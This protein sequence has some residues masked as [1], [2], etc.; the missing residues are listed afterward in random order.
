MLAAIE[1]SLAGIT[2]K[3]GGGDP[4]K[5]SDVTANATWSGG[6]LVE[7]VVGIRSEPSAIPY[8]AAMPTG[9]FHCVFKRF[10]RGAN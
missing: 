2:E 5:R 3:L 6:C 10:A 8:G 7:S 4:S 9:E 1:R